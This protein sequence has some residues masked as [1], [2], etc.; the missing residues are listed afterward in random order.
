MTGT[1]LLLS[2]DVYYLPVRDGVWLRTAEGSFV[3]RG[4]DVAA[5]LARLGPLFD[6]GVTPEQLFDSLAPAQAR[7]LRGL[8]DL[9]RQRQV[10]RRDPS[11]A[12]TGE[13]DPTGGNGRND[14]R[15]AQ[16]AGMVVAGPAGYAALAADALAQAG[17][18]DIVVPADPDGPTAT[19]LAGR[20][21]VGFFPA[22]QADAALA[23]ADRVAA[24]GA[25]TWLG[26][27][28]GRALLLKGH[29]AGHP[30]ACPRCAWRRLNHRSVA[31]PTGDGIGAAAQLAAGVL[32]QEVARV[33]VDGDRRPLGEAAVID[34]D[35][36]QIWRSAVDVDPTCPTVGRHDRAGVPTPRTA[37]FPN[38]VLGAR[39]FGPLASC[40]PEGLPQLP[41]TML[42]LVL[43]PVGRAEPA[44]LRDGPLVVAETMTHA[45]TES[46]SLSVERYL[47]TGSGAA[48]GVAV[49][50]TV[51]TARALTHWADT[52]LTDGW[53]DRVVDQPTAARHRLGGLAGHL[54]P[55]RH[56]AHPSG[57]WRAW[58]AGGAPLTG[59]GPEQAEQRALLAALAGRQHPGWSGEVTPATPPYAGELPQR[60]TAAL[61]L[62]ARPAPLPALVSAHLVGVEIGQ[63][64]GR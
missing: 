26:L 14:G 28:R 51:A 35:T 13:A 25:G 4:R 54:P 6:R 57:M 7:Y 37:S 48:V 41:L 22:G 63:D 31:L 21:L 30:S 36:L 40:S 47:P 45:R 15:P 64:G 24:D 18:R 34:L 39:C 1:P 20:H 38:L 55:V 56:Q 53:S 8:V 10:L 46:L 62:R 29:L 19:E 59:L 23:L 12:R 11:D 33:L 52:W 43:N 32:S 2:D 50:T 9:L 17:F 5:W 27:V 42:R 49:D 58:T 3:L 60:H 61:G 44:T 16:R